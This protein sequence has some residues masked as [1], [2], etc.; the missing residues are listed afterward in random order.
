MLGNSSLPMTSA[1][2][3]IPAH[4][5]FL[6][7]LHTSCF[8]RVFVAVFAMRFG[9]GRGG[10]GSVAKFQTSKVGLLG[11]VKNTVR[12]PTQLVSSKDGVAMNAGT[13]RPLSDGQR[14]AIMRD[15]YIAKPIVG[16]FFARR[17]TAIVRAVRAIVV[18]ALKSHAWRSWP[19][20]S[21]KVVKHKPPITNSDTST[22]IAVV[23]SGLKVKA[24][25]LNVLPAHINRAARFAMSFVHGVTVLHWRGKIK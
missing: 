24:S 14:Y 10:L 20:V 3:A 17:P 1:F 6:G 22:T 12:T 9:S 19:Q 15:A 25:L 5:S 18:N 7:N 16:L 23:M 11:W 21:N 4:G 8:R 13:L 2:L